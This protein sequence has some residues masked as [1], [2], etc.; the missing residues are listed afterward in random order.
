MTKSRRKSAITC[1]CEYLK[2]HEPCSGRSIGRIFFGSAAGTYEK[3]SNQLKRIRGGFTRITFVIIAMMLISI[4][5]NLILA[6]Y[7]RGIYDGPYQ[8]MAV[9]DKIEIEMENLQR[10]IYTGIA[11]DDPEFIRAA[12]SQFDGNLKNLEEYIGTLIT[13]ASDSESV[14]INLFRQKIGRTGEIIKRIETHL[15]AFDADNN[16]EYQIA[17]NVMRGEAI[18]IFKSAATTFDVLKKQ[19]EQAAADYLQNAMYAQAMV[20]GLMVISLIISIVVS[21]KVSKR[22]E[23]E[24]VT[25]VEELVEV[26][27]MLSRGELDVDI[28]YNKKNELGVLADS[29]R[30]IIATLRDLI[31]EADSLSS[32]A[33]EGDLESRGNAERFQGGYREIIQGVNHTLDALIYPLKTSADYME[34]IS[35][36]LIPERITEEAKGDFVEINHS[37]NTC[38]DAVNRLVEDT[39]E[40]VNAAIHGRLGQR[41]DG[42]SHGG[43]FAKVIDG[44]NK[45]I[46]TLVG[47]IDA[48]PSPVMILNKDF[49]IQYI[50]RSGASLTGLSQEELIGTKC[51]DNLHADDCGSEN[52]ACLSAMQQGEMAV[53]DTVVRL[54]EQEM[55]ISYT[56]I[57]LTDGDGS[58]IGALELIVDHTEIKNAARQAERN[59]ETARRQAEFQDQEVN[60]LIVNLEKLAVGDLSI[61]TLSRETDEATRKIGD[62]FDKINSYLNNCV[63]AIQALIDDASEMTV[64]AVE[65]RLE[66]RAETSRHG[67]S[68]AKIMEGLNQTLDAVVEPVGNALQVLQALEQGKLGTQ[69]EGD[70][71]GD[72]A[73]IKTTM[74]STIRNIQSYIREISSVLTEVADGNLDLAITADYKGEFVE[75][76]DSLNNIIVTLSQ[77]MGDINDAAE[78]VSS[79]SRQVSDGSQTLSQGSTQQASSIQELT[80]SISEIAAQTKR[81]AANANQANGHANDAKVNAEQGDLK[82]KGM[83]GSMGEINES[84]ANISRIIKVI[85]DIAFQTNILALNAAVEAARAGQHG[86]GFAVVAEEVRNLAARSAAAA[87][88]TTDLIEGSI[89]KVQAGT[90]LANETAFALNEIVQRIG[91]AADIVG[92]IADA[93]NEQASAIAQINKGIEQVSEVVQNNSATAEESAAASEELSGQAELLKEMVGRFRLNQGA[94]AL[95]GNHQALPESRSPEEYPQSEDENPR[96]I[97][98]EDEF[99]KY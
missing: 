46:N 56:G 13:L 98:P 86:K 25:P 11:E 61:E 97:L 3:R 50:N 7:A 83:L 72:Y 1:P 74:N 5:S 31:E 88:E 87:R 8:R 40:L 10:N 2:K 54:G 47:H 35:K 9:I 43:D 59:M 29:M 21:G 18:P 38:I 93:S 96:I 62:N 92:E 79:G 53:R 12:V 65:G 28:T 41:A 70:Y 24:I 42:S 68:F 82:M 67:G 20:V 80:A 27:T 19:S 85:D 81:N 94:K 89:E 84:S 51:Y 23:R 32:A 90:K 44:V 60:Q 71:Q 69:M 26:S 4:I 64:A 99:D 30:G 14:E 36:G 78:Q 58:I 33:V 95:P 37:I 17:L 55:E 76:K 22:L 52:C 16:N 91:K 48:L 77:V 6:S 57:P 45:T 49:E 66:H 34:Q 75:I 63:A 39:G 73:V 15:T